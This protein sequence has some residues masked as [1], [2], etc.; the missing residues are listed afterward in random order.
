MLSK[1][2]QS[3]AGQ[4][5]E[6]STLSLSGAP[7]IPSV[8]RESPQSPS[9]ITVFLSYAR[10]DNENFDFIVPFK[11][12][13]R[14]F[15][16]AKSGRRIRAFIDQENISWGEIWR[17]RLERE[18]LG[19]AVFIPL[20][21]TSYLESEACRMEYNK[22]QAVAQANNVI[23]LL[24]P[25]LLFQASAVFNENSQ[26]DL[27]LDA[28]S[29]EYEC[30]EEAVLSNR[31]SQ[32]WKRTMARLADRFTD[33]YQVAESRLAVVETT[34]SPMANESGEID[35]DAPGITEVME[36]FQNHI[37]SMTEAVHALEPA[38]LGLGD[39][40]KD[41]G[42]LKENPSPKEIQVW[43][44]RA[45]KLFQEP[46]QQI[47]NQGQKL[48][49]ATKELDVAVSQMRRIAIELP[50]FGLRES[51]NQMM[52]NLQGLDEVREQM[53]SLLGSLRPAEYLS[54]PLRRSLQPARTGLTRIADAISIIETWTQL[55]A[56]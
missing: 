34:P 36:G 21:S 33:A 55:E 7:G 49:L 10:S 22:F 27:V 43:T 26:D 14:A 38:I 44:L 15:V 29:R 18:V 24:L 6:D 9:E 4:V 54:V 47:G 52:S 19:A 11:E 12:L 28:I 56:E 42:G 37:E 1:Q 39:A 2:G 8:T 35:V 30:V 20:L 31:G 45:A 41:V 40:A 25:V 53:K 17:E 16:H 50:G 48:F 32:E 5:V 23:E 3:S 51:Y 13:L 46:A